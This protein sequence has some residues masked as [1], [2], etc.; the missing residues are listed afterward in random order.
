M[1]P[2]H[3]GRQNG[4]TPWLLLPSAASVARRSPTA[5]LTTAARYEAATW[6]KIVSTSVVWPAGKSTCLR[7]GTRMPFISKRLLLS[8][9]LPKNGRSHSKRQKTAGHNV[10]AAKSL[11]SPT[12]SPRPDAKRKTGRTGSCSPTRRRAPAHDAPPR[13][14]GETAGPYRNWPPCHRRGPRAS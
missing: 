3:M 11:C 1:S 4:R 10:P 8:P 6:A 14:A 12:G 2:V 9:P 5:Q 7:P 13:R